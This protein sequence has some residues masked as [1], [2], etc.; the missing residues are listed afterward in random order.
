MECNSIAETFLFHS[1]IK[2]IYPSLMSQ[3]LM[4]TIICLPAG[5]HASRT[6]RPWWQL[7]SWPP[8]ISRLRVPLPSGSWQLADEQAAPK[9]SP[10]IRP[11]ASKIPATLWWPTQGWVLSAHTGECPT[12]YSHFGMI[13]PSTE[14]CYNQLSN[15]KKMAFFFLVKGWHSFCR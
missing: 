7:T 5:S 12:K 1:H 9:L 3:G 11:K 13:I 15:T 4:M 2:L 8:L 14:F 6:L 10:W